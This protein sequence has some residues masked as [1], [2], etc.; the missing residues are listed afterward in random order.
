MIGLMGAEH[1]SR[2]AYLAQM[3]RLKFYP[4]N[5][6]VCHNHYGRYRETLSME[7]IRCHFYSNKCVRS[8]FNS[9]E[10]NWI[11]AKEICSKETSFS[12]FAVSFPSKNVKDLDLGR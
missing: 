8:R 3:A 11:G 2:G 12:V 1:S 6:E 5:S 7:I 10:S 4:S 9:M